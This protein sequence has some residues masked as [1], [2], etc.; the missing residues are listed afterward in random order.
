VLRR[1]SLAAGRRV[2]P[3]VGLIAVVVGWMASG[4]GATGLPDGRVY[5]LVSP[6]DK[7]GADVL[8]LSA[9]TQASAD[10]QAVKFA[11]L[12]GF[13]DVQGTG[14]STE[15]MSE[16]SSDPSPGTNGWRTHA[17]TPLQKPLTS[18]EAVAGFDPLYQGELSPDL[19]LGVFW[20]AT[21]LTDAPNVA[22]V[23]NLYVRRDLHAPGAGSYQLATDCPG[24]R[25]PLA[26]PTF[27]FGSTAYAIPT[28]VGASS[29]FGRVAFEDFEN[30]TADAAGLDPTVPKV[31]VFDR[32]SVA[33]AGVL[34]D[35]TPAPISLAGQGVS[36]RGG[37]VAGLPLENYPAHVVSADGARIFFEANPS[38]CGSLS[39]GDLY[40]RQLDPSPATTVQLNASERTDCAGDPTCGGNGIPDPAPDPS[41]HQLATYW[42][43][44]VDGKRAFFTSSEQ[45]TDDA[46]SGAN[47][48]YMYDTTKPASD[49]HNLTV[50]S[51]DED[52]ADGPSFVYGVI[53][54]SDD[55]HYVYFIAT[56]RLVAGQPDVPQSIYLWHDGTVSYVAELAYSGDIN[57]DLGGNI[58]FEPKLARV[59]SDGQHLLF[60]SRSG[61]G[62]GGYDQG[63]CISIS[64]R[65]CHF[66][67]YVYSVASGPD[68]EHLH[69]ASC[70]PSGAPATTDAFDNAK[71]NESAARGNWHL[72]HPLSDDGTRA[73]FST[74]EAL[75]PED[76]NGKVDAYEWEAGGAG[77]CDQG[78]GCIHLLST[79]T[80]TFNSFFM[81]ASTDG[82][83]A[84]FVTRQRL[85]GWDTD[86][87]NDLYDARV[88]GGFPEP[89]PASPPCQ[90]DTCRSLLSA[91]PSASVPGSS[92][93]HE[94]SRPAAHRHRPLHCRRG[95]TRKRVH[96][97]L[98]CVRKHRAHH[99][100]A[101]RARV[102]A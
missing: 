26:A 70:N 81:D 64:P 46:P 4:A 38:G 82:T 57:N 80:D 32:G 9:R 78:S 16:R 69:C 34:P 18:Q 42:G 22:N 89:T 20:T 60:A 53:G 5:E 8:T 79:G 41:G 61:E 10:G 74:Q 59:T 33:L 58:R 6:P 87:N 23:P 19:G 102:R 76:V 71:E 12:E 67:L 21:P 3:V 101:H 92:T 77:S 98:R 13:G 100:R 30:L 65:I 49:P 45:L 36:G 24:C 75:V 96:G 97:R 40:L 66:E 31:Y 35:G 55:G 28:F 14:V 29:D 54:T 91:I 52:T 37:G 48:L 83:N 88:G 99:R 1:A 94:R 68:G 50:L 39:C 15:Y 17:I 2:V 62:L 7:N 47:N 56:G 95:F 85:V 73:F 86:S 72:G 51:T 43:A 27:G 84:F 11:S 93:F 90:G 44:S 63:S 25:S